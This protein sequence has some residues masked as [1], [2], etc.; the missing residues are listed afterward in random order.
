MSSY[1]GV[2]QPIVLGGYQS[3]GS[4]NTGSNP[5]GGH[6]HG[7][8]RADSEDTQEGESDSDE[9]SRGRGD[10]KSGQQH[11]KKGG[12]QIHPTHT[13]CLP[14]G[15]HDALQT[16]VRE[17]TDA[18]LASNPPIEGLDEMMVIEPA[19]L[20]ITLGEMHLKKYDNTASHSR[21][22]ATEGAGASAQE[23]EQIKTVQQALD[24]LG[25]LRSEITEI[26]SSSLEGLHVN[27]DTMG[28]LRPGKH[29]TAHV[30]W[31]G[32]EPSSGPQETT[33]GQVAVIVDDAFRREGFMTETQPLTLHCTIAKTSKAKARKARESSQPDKRQRRRAERYGFS[34]SAIF[35]SE[36]YK[37]TLDAL[38]S[39]TQ[40]TSVTGAQTSR[41]SYQRTNFGTWSVDE[42]QLCVMGAIDSNTGAFGSVG[43]IQI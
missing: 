37:A 28:T 6:A 14:L 42:I 5:T 38:S 26:T 17:F 31:I 39:T 4:H 2:S 33:L 15:H 24:L 43:G 35:E 41:T 9:R 12:K 30:L 34:I 16:R 19:R 22:K 36:A 23:G 13:L 3:G 11:G 1:T 25:S 32:P 8:D 40:T 21:R 10:A 27:L 7:Q 20:H 18:L 29:E